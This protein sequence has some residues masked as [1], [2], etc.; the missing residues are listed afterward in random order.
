MVAEYFEDELEDRT[1]FVW[2]TW[3]LNLLML[4]YRSLQKLNELSLETSVESSH[5]NRRSPHFN[6]GTNISMPVTNSKL[7]LNSIYCS[8]DKDKFAFSFFTL[9]WKSNSSVKTVFSSH[10][11]TFLECQMSLKFG[12]KYTCHCV[13]KPASSWRGNTKAGLKM[14]TKLSLV[15]LKIRNF[16]PYVVPFLFLYRSFIITS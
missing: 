9:S 3:T 16:F 5:V 1:P 4:R 6:L 10:I 13:Q 8:R 14:S 12:G 2:I 7:R 15:G 11:F